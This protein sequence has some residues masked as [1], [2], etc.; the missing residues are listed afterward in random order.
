MFHRFRSALP[1]TVLVMVLGL[2]A[3]GYAFAQDPATP[4]AGTTGTPDTALCATPVTEGDGTPV[5]VATPAD[6]AATPGG[7]APGTPIGLYPCATPV[8]ASPVTETQAATPGTTPSVGAATPITVEFIDVAFAQTELTI[9]ANTD[10]PFHFVNVGASPHNFTIDDPKVFSGDLVSGATSDVVVNLP[11][12]TY[13]YYC[14]IPG[15]R[16]AGM[17][18]TLIVQ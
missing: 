3:S 15:H 2:A 14:S 12:G 11:A 16:E 7:V 8:N 6:T 13:E 17:I 9:P 1:V 18:G 4:A 5:V 10:V